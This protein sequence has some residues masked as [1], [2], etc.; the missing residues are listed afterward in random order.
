MTFFKIK[1]RPFHFLFVFIFIWTATK[2]ILASPMESPTPF[3]SSRDNVILGDKDKDSL[4]LEKKEG[5]WHLMKCEDPFLCSEVKVDDVDEIAHHLKDFE[6]R[7]IQDYCQ[8]EKEDYLC[9]LFALSQKLT[10]SK[11]TRN[12]Q[13]IGVVAMAV[14]EV[15]LGF[16]MVVVYGV[17]VLIGFFVGGTATVLSVAT[18][19]VINTLVFL[20]MSYVFMDFQSNAER[21]AFSAKNIKETRQELID[22]LVTEDEFSKDEQLIQNPMP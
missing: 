21:F 5:L 22:L 4:Y 15:V 16:V 11:E 9:D 20:L 2:P 19:I 14:M 12:Q 1:N 17:A 18:A 8:Q 6:S 10:E 7:H 13:A 3:S